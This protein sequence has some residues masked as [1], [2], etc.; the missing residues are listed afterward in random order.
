MQGTEKQVEWATKIRKDKMLDIAPQLDSMAKR[1][2]GK[3]A[4]IAKVDAVRDALA[5][6]PAAWWIDNRDV[7]AMDLLKQ[8]ARDTAQASA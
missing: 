2:A 6:K 1:L 8:A 7:F 5:A 4:E 3:P